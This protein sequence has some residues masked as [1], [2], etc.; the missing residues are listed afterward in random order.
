MIDTNVKLYDKQSYLYLVLSATTNTNGNNQC[1]S[2]AVRTS[3]RARIN[4]VEQ[5]WIA[6]L[7]LVVVVSVDLAL[8][9]GCVGWL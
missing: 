1:S 2:Y 3:P 7:V 9:C 8:C 4:A 6:T 5:T